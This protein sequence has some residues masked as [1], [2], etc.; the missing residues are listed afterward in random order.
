MCMRNFITIFLSAQEIGPFS[1]FQNSELG[2]GSS[3]NKCH[4][5]IPWARSCQYQCVCKI[6]LKYSKRFKLWAFFA[7]CPVTKSCKLSV[8]KI[9]ASCPG[10]DTV[11]IWHSLKVNIQLHCWSAFFG[12]IRC[13][14]YYVIE[15]SNF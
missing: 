8:D 12:S 10:T 13:H 7:N 15:I 14:E 6:L 4:F 5:A 11:I 9:F 3:D 1:H 2:K